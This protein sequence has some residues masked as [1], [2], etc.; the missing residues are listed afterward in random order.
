MNTKPSKLKAKLAVKILISLGILAA[1]LFHMDR[2]ALNQVIHTVHASAWL[3]ALLFIVV[4]ILLQSLRWMFLINIGNYR[5]SFSDSLQVTLASLV[6]NILFITTISGIVVRVALAYQH[7]ASLFKSIF[8]TTID[9]FTT[10]G[11]LLLLC[12]IVLPALGSVLDASLIT[13]LSLY[14]AILML[15]LFVFTPLFIFTL[16]YKMPQFRLSKGNMRSGFRYLKLFFNNHTL[17]AKILI[18]SLLAQICFFLSVYCIVWSADISLSFMHVMIVLPAIAVVSSIPISF[19][20]WGVREGAF[21]YG[22]GLL[23]V[24]IEVAFAISV[25][26]GLIGLLA[27]AVTGLPVLAFSDL[28][29][30][31]FKKQT[32]S[33]KS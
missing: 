6:A 19:G 7:G 5:M 11:A 24:P 25:Q 21:V 33:K 29:F 9:R 31:N 13:D 22:L 14:V 3:Y 17:L 32:F 27:P 20:G 2:D 26:V 16:L 15:V 18:I 30:K 10:L 8:A 1:L 4:Q 12:I 23:G 28:S